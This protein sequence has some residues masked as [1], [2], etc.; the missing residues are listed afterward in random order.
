MEDSWSDSDSDELPENCCEVCEL[1]F[2]PN[3]TVCKA[4]ARFCSVCDLE[5]ET[6][7]FECTDCQPVPPEEEWKL[8]KWDREIPVYGPTATYYTNDQGETVI[9]GFEMS[10]YTLALQ[11]LRRSL[12]WDKRDYL[13]DRKATLNLAHRFQLSR[14][15]W[16]T[17]HSLPYCYLNY[18]VLFQ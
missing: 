13:S 4:C 10:V 16:T 15:T 8:E 7:S 17:F 9:H 18:T 6:N 5:Y 1:E 2:E 12:D 11:L 3:S 14:K